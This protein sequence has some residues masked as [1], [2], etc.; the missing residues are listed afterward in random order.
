MI[1]TVG[2]M[3][4][5]TIAAEVDEVP[6]PDLVGQVRETRSAN[7]AYRAEANEWLATQEAEGFT[8]TVAALATSYYGPTDAPSNCW[9]VSVERLVQS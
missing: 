9:S 7:F 6:R 5:V 2:I 3:R 4:W 8:G 1:G